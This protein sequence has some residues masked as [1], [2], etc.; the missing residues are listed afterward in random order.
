VRSTLERRAHL[1]AGVLSRRFN[2]WDAAWFTA[3]L[4]DAHPAF[5]VT[6][7]LLSERAG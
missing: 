5:V 6:E 3:G 7:A 2:G 4:K 1:R